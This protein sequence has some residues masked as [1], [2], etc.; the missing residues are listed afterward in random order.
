MRRGGNFF[1]FA[2]FASLF[3]YLMNSGT[4]WPPYVYLWPFFKYMAILLSVPVILN[5]IPK[6]HGKQIIIVAVIGILVIVVG[7]NSNTLFNMLLSYFAIIGAKE[8]PFRDIVKF[9]FYI[10][11]CFC[12]FN[13]FISEIGWINKIIITTSTDRDN[14]FGEIVE[15]KDFGY[16]WATDYA[17]HVFF[18][19]LDYWVLKNGRLN[20]KEIIIYVGICIFIINSCV[21][22]LAAFCILLIVALSLYIR[23][24]RKKRKQI[25]F[26]TSIILILITPIFA[27]ITYF[28]TVCYDN[29]NINWIGLDVIMSGRLS[30]GYNAI[31]DV[32]IPWFG[33]IFKMYGAVNSSSD[34]EYNYLDSSYIQSLVIWGLILTIV[35][36]STYVAISYKAYKRKDIVLMF[37]VFLTAF[38]GIIA[39]FSCSM[40]YCILLIA[41]VASHNTITRNRLT[42]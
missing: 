32:G 38:V 3:L 29:S 12:L 15:R 39:Q 26:V 27:L 11:L 18:I 33:Q 13:M 31:Q 28:V 7:I 34:S 37:A 41:A 8:V 14:L 22:R 2:Y 36:I 24:L 25:G 17:I 40:T 30:L 21:A 35:W 10:A 6:Y 42:A 19:L 9:H 20:L 5:S 23:Y 1:F 16:G 4:L